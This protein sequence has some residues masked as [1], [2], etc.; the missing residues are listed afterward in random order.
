[1]SIF[2]FSFDKN[3]S[4]TIVRFMRNTR[5][6][7]LCAF[8]GGMLCAI[9]AAPPL[10]VPVYDFSAIPDSAGVRSDKQVLER[11]ITG[12]VSALGEMQ[13]EIHTDDTGQKFQIRAEDD[14]T[15]ISVVIIP[16]KTVEITEYT[17]GGVFSTKSDAY[18]S[19]DPGTWILKRDKTLGAVVSLTYFFTGDKEVYVSFMPGTVSGQSLADL[20]IFGAHVS[21]SIKIPAPIDYFFT[22]SIFDVRKKTAPLLQWKYVTVNPYFYRDS[23][24]M[25][26]VIR[27]NLKRVIFAPDAAYNE[28][29][30]SI[31]VITGEK[32]AIDASVTAAKKLELSDAGFVKWIVDGLIERGAGNYTKIPPLTSKTYSYA[33]GSFLGT[34][35]TK[36][37]LTFSLDWTRNLAI[38]A[39]SVAA[40]KNYPPSFRGTDVTDS[41]F[42]FSAGLDY[43]EGSGYNSKSL[44]AILYALCA[45]E[46]DTFFLAAIRETERRTS[47]E[48]NYFNKSAVIFTYFDSSAKLKI[49][50]FEN[51]TE[52]SLENFLA[53]Y[54]GSFIHLSRV[55]ASE[56][57]SL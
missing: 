16:R 45:T 11:W 42:I 35:D 28:K 56:R 17:S 37:N 54:P 21:R 7:F 46:S 47:P 22:A 57:F 23:L 48:V 12:P 43:I 41:P 34:L 50:I 29:G 49:T 2:Y 8:F 19:G 9:F 33:P 52:V 3:T 32:R 26:D 53:K 15:H 13:M 27:A 14:G 51:G 39:F 30:E 38:A 10:T 31:A 40:G 1:M 36:Y 18:I 4:R 24:Y 6:F 44:K 25:I 20:V 5:R 55:K